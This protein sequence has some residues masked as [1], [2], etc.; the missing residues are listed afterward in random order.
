MLTPWEQ[1]A[2]PDLLRSFLISSLDVLV[3]S[4][5]TAHNGSCILGD[6]PRVILQGWSQPSLLKHP[7]VSTAFLDRVLVGLLSSS[8]MAKPVLRNN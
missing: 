5:E 3:P 1:S 7:T 6:D 4:A 8:T 2:V